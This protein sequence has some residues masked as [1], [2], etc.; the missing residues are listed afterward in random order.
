[1]TVTAFILVFISAF[2]HASWN[3][4]CKK[5]HPDIG[6]FVVYSM[7]IL[8]TI[9]PIKL[10]SEISI[11]NFSAKVWYCL[12][13]GGICGALGNF[14]LIFAYRKEDIS[15]VY[16]LGRALPVVL[17]TLT[18]TALGI[19]RGLNVWIWLGMIVIFI[20]CV[21][22]SIN[23]FRHVRLKDYACSGMFGV[24]LLSIA[25][26]GYTIIDG[27]GINALHNLNSG[28]SRLLE[29]ANYYCCREAVNLISM[30]TVVFMQ[31]KIQ[32]KISWKFFRI[33]QSYLSGIFSGLAYLLVL[34][35]SGLVTNVSYVQAFRQ[36]SL[37]LAM[38]FGAYF[39]HERIGFNKIL[40][41]ILIVIGLLIITLA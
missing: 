12:I 35:A 29:A 2:L 32:L 38:L 37:P 30:I 10:F 18:T 33:P 31:K 36:L 6:F 22:M 7:A 14:G 34:T 17:T 9:I 41:M 27:I 8:L 39:L 16:P 1:M 19:G 3:F 25:I 11:F 15:K 13:G 23:N 21:I 5:Q 26:T 4:M 40:A 20:G 28:S 24:M